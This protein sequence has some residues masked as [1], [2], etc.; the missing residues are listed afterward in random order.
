MSPPSL[1]YPSFP[2]PIAHKCSCRPQNIS[3]VF[4]KS[5][6]MSGFLT[7]RLTSKHEDDFYATVPGKIARGEIKCA[8]LNAPTLLY[9]GADG[10]GLGMLNIGMKDWRRQSR[11]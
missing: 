6:K 1:E 3:H 11:R 7:G 10:R 5:I 8:P 2:G 9:G 4:A